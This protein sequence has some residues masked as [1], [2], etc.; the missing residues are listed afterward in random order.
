MSQKLSRPA[1]AQL[2]YHSEWF[3]KVRKL[4]ESQKADWLNR[5]NFSHHTSMAEWGGRFTA[6]R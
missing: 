5:I 2:L 4:V 6:V 3:L 1:P